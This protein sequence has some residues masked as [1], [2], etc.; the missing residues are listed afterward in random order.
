M[1]IYETVGFH[2]IDEPSIT[3]CFARKSTDPATAIEGVLKRAN[4]Y[5]SLPKEKQNSNLTL[6]CMIDTI[7]TTGFLEFTAQP[8][9]LLAEGSEHLEWL[10]KEFP[11]VAIL[12]GETPRDR[13]VVLKDDDM[14]KCKLVFGF[15]KL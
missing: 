11:E 10:K 2:L 5:S 4:W 12:P 7:A 9:R 1:V 3:V 8:A 6:E 13:I 14:V 15:N